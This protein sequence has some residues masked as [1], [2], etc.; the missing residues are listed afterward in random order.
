MKKSISRLAGLFCL[1]KGVSALV[2]R[3]FDKD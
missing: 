1:L 3:A 2:I